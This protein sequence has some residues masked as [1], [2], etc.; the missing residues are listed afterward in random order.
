MKTI[1][2]QQ[3]IQTYR[4]K[5]FIMLAAFCISLLLVRAALTHSIFFFFLIWNLFLAYLPLAITS[6]LLNKI[7]WMEKKLYFY[8]IFICWLLVLPNAPYIITDFVHLQREL[9]VPVWFDVLL[10][11]SFTVTGLLFGLASMKHMFHIIAAQRGKRQGKI[12]M[13][14]VCLLSAY[15][16]YLGRYLRYN[17]WDIINRPASLFIDIISSLANPEYYKASLGIT[18]GF[19]TL[20]YLLF[21][22]YNDND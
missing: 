11:I 2:L 16:I 21:S 22:L 20:L 19:G 10:L 5:T 14:A 13:A 1:K 17:S 6:V 8:P 4:S 12:I 3:P 15:G 7:E 9:D 18:L